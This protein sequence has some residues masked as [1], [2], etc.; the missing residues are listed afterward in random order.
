M[1]EYVDVTMRPAQVVPGLVSVTGL[2]WLGVFLWHVAPPVTLVVLGPAL[3]ACF[4]PVVTAPVYGVRLAAERWTVLQGKTD[5][6]IDVAEIAYLAV[7][8]TRKARHASVVLKDGREVD[9]PVTATSE[10]IRLIQ[11]AIRRNIPVRLR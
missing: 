2:L 8:A 1:E 11:E 4:F 10:P 9:I 5:H 3:A 7:E 6:F